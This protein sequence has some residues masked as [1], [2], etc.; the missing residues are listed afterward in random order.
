MVDYSQ[1]QLA[2]RVHTHLNQ[3]IQSADRKASIVL[4]GQLAFLGLG[5]SATSNLL[6]GTTQL[7]TILSTISAAFGVLA[8]LLSIWVIYPSTPS[9]SEGFIY[10]GNIL[11]F[12]DPEEYREALC[13]LNSEEAVEEV[14]KENYELAKVADSKYTQLRWS[15]RATL[16]MVVM[17]GMAG[18]IHII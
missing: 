13:G 18:A 14:L 9:P 4:T 11:E 2:E 15:L 8:V 1:E 7:F 6:N 10:W 12:R 16:L 17:A 3:Y 5:A